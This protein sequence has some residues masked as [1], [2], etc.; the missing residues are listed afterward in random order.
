MRLGDVIMD[1][2]DMLEVIGLRNDNKTVV[3]EVDG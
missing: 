1:V 3:V 2:S